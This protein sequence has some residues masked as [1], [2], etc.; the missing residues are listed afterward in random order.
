[1]YF[2]KLAAVFTLLLVCPTLLLAQLP[3]SPA[4][5]SATQPSVD[6]A[7]GRNYLLLLRDGTNI[8]GRIVRRDSIVLTVRKTNGQLTYVEPELLDRIMALSD[9][10]HI[11]LPDEPRKQQIVLKDGTTLIGRV[12]GRT[13]AV[14]TIEL[15]D[16]QVTF[17]ET[18]LVSQINPLETGKPNQERP[19]PFTPFLLQ[20]PSAANARQGAFY[21][22]NSWLIQ[23]ELVW[24]VTN[25]L[26]LGV[27]YTPTNWFL[28]DQGYV[29]S[30][31]YTAQLGFPIGPWFR[32]ATSVSHLPYQ[33]YE[34]RRYINVLDWQ[35][36]TGFGDSR[37]LLTLAYGWQTNSVPY[38]RRYIRLGAN[39]QLARRVAF[40]TDNTIYVGGPYSSFY[41]YGF[42]SSLPLTG[43]LYYATTGPSARLAVALRFGGPQQ[44]FDVGVMAAVSPS[45]TILSEYVNAQPYIGYSLYF[46]K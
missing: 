45:G 10:I 36:L 27:T 44:A 32:I 7:N 22:R 3:T 38:Q 1:M 8:R 25:F 33:N 29:N 43:S 16:G 19:G 2:Y 4:P 41:Y 31:R 42:S 15:P 35:V 26:S 37:H 11:D 9:D 40:I 21:Y 18:A 13:D 12:R 5:L 39:M 17:V 23:N 34:A 28:Q 6:T 24:G 46:G 30:L 20:H 14:Y